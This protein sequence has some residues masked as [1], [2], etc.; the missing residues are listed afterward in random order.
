M[1]TEQVAELAGISPVSVRRYTWRGVI[2]EPERIGGILL[3]KRDEI[4]QWLAERRKPGRPRK[5]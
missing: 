4:E 1:T 5:A 2:P 3:W